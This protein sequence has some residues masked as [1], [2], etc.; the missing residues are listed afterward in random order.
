MNFVIVSSRQ[1]VMK[2]ILCLFLLLV[3]EVKLNLVSEIRD[4]G[5]ASEISENYCKLIEERIGKI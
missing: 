2:M 4:N 5:I 3:L 1:A